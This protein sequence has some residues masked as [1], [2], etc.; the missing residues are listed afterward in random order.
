VK[1]GM[2]LLGRLRG[3]EK[4]SFPSSRDVD[5]DEA[6]RDREE[7]KRA[8]HE[9]YNLEFKRA[10]VERMKRRGRSAGSVTLGDR[11]EKFAST[12]SKSSS[13]RSSGGSHRGYG[14]RGNANPF[15]SMFDSGISYGG[16]TQ[17]KM[18]KGK[19]SKVKKFDMFDNWGYMK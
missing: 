18:K 1:K 8:E 7:Q 6:R 19:K 12:P 13:P 5:R 17:F 2:S 15:G 14:T 11:L 3:K 16:P 10:R 4:V 9:A